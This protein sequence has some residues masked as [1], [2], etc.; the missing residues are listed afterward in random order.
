VPTETLVLSG[1]LPATP[2]RIYQAWMDARDHSAMTGSKATVE[3]GA[4][5]GRFTAWAGYIEGTHVAL[6]P[7]RRIL[8]S[9][10]TT[11]FPPDAP[12]SYLEVKLEPAPGGA[13][14]TFRHSDVPAEQAAGYLQGWKDYYLKPMARFFAAEAKRGAKKRGAKKGPARGAAKKKPAKRV[15]KR[16]KPKGVRKAARGARR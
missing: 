12:E 3:S 2:A 5:G 1:L 10:R 16:A 11:E 7:G 9:W 14:I 8:Q 13:R 15:V 6:E 4:V